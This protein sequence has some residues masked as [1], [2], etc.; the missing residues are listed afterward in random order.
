MLFHDHD[1]ATCPI[2]EAT[3]FY[4][5]KDEPSCWKVLYECDECSWSEMPGRISRDDVAHEDDAW[6]RA[7]EFG[8]QW[9]T[10]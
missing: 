7:V 2:C 10:N 1:E 9:V 8:E 3:V 6:D 4:T 5:L